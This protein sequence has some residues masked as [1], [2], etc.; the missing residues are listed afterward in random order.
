MSQLEPVQT[1]EEVID[2][3]LPAIDGELHGTPIPDRCLPAAFMFME[4]IVL[5]VEGDDKADFFSKPWFR[6]IYQGIVSWYRKHYADAV[7]RQPDPLIGACKL[8]G[9]VFELHVPRTL[10]EVETEDETAW[11]IFPEG[12]GEREFASDWIL[13]PPN[14]TLLDAEHRNALLQDLEKVGCQLRSIFVNLME[15]DADEVTRELIRMVLPHLCGAATH[16]VEHPTRNLGLACWDAHQAVEK[17]LKALCRQQ[18]GNHRHTHDVRRLRD[19]LVLGGPAL[20]ED[21]LLCRIPDDKRIVAIRA[22][23]V[24]VDLVEAYQVYRACL[25][26]T[27]VC[28]AGAK[29]KYRFHNFRLLLRKPAFI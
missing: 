26:A 3:W 5:E 27:A 16:L 13:R 18:F 11:L 6:P 14:L 2:L 8:L 10:S 15:R 23:E 19:D 17:M 29:R 20:V 21:A 24:R 9:A 22:G 1:I 12:L 28:A 7:D 25:D 4:S